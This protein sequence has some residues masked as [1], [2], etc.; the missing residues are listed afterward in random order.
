MKLILNKE[1]RKVRCTNRHCGGFGNDHLVPYKFVRMYPF[2]HGLTS[3][4]LGLIDRKAKIILWHERYAIE[5]AAAAF[6]QGSV[7][8][9]RVPLKE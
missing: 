1:Y 7:I 6:N 8:F 4:R 3:C 2:K 5:N 9:Q